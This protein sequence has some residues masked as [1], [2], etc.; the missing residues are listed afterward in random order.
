MPSLASVKIR[1]GLATI[2]LAAAGLLSWLLVPGPA[3][4]QA[5]AAPTSADLPAASAAPTRPVEPI[6]PAEPVTDPDV[7][8]TRLSYGEGG[9]HDYLAYL[10]A[11]RSTDL[12]VLLVHG[13]SWVG[14]SAEGTAR[15][16]QRLYAQGIA[17]F[18]IDYRL[19]TRAAWP[20]Q[21]HDLAGALAA[22]RAKAA[23]WH[24]NPRRIAVIGVSAGGH[25]ALDLADRA[26]P[27]GVCAVV[28]YSGPTSM[29]LVL[30]E[31][32]DGPKQHRLAHAVRLL[33]PTAKDRRAATLPA[34]PS[35]RDA[36]A[37]LF[38]AQDEWVDA[39]NTTRYAEA[40][41]G[42]PVDVEAV[43]L[44]G[45][46]RHASGYALTVPDVWYRTVAFL[47]RHCD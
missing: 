34:S 45:V 19:A 6:D 35:A 32:G 44:P 40:Y 36:P 38:A 16:N 13:G 12:A 47:H 27:D 18:S 30:D 3:T 8:P 25:L 14:G 1:L 42:L 21:R 37:L 46:S 39:R 11:G 7:R 9:A 26:G 24:I 31:A 33:A 20:A 28:S 15:Y 10:P 17:S 4:S 2:T 29:Q 43:V 41:R 23:D 22:I 5:A